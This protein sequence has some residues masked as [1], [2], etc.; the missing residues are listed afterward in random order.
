MLAQFLDSSIKVDFKPVVPAQSIYRSLPSY[1]YRPQQ[2][3]SRKVFQTPTNK[4]INYSVDIIQTIYDNTNNEIINLEHLLFDLKKQRDYLTDIIKQ[5]NKE[6]IEKPMINDL[7]NDG[8]QYNNKEKQNNDINKIYDDQNTEELTKIEK[9]DNNEIQQDTNQILTPIPVELRD[10]TINNVKNLEV[11]QKSENDENIDI[12]NYE[13]NNNEDIEKIKHFS[14]NINTEKI[15]E[16][17]NE[18]TGINGLTNK[19]GIKQILDNIS[20]NQLSNVLSSIVD[21]KH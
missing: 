12:S 13:I 9:T 3:Y 11:N 18:S 2:N 21:S 5:K 20:E 14:E 15:K 16:V 19:E 17:F 1:S 10:E 7:T 8:I 6:T 4:S